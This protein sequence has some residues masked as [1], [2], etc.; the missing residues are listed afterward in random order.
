MYFVWVGAGDCNESQLWGL[1][2]FQYL[3]P[4]GR[5]NTCGEVGVGEA[6]AE[7]SVMKVFTGRY[8]IHR[9]IVP[10]YVPSLPLPTETNLHTLQASVVLLDQSVHDWAN[11]RGR[12]A[13]CIV[14][15]PRMQ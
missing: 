12:T 9:F 10:C 7:S 13:L 1:L 8:L 2:V 5:R 14:C 11:W 3:L 6:T 4:M 15:A